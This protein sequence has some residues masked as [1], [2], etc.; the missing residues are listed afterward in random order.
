MKYKGEVK[1]RT[2]RFVYNSISSALYQVTSIAGGFILTRM[3][4][5]TYGS[6][7]NG[8]VI[9]II[10]FVSYF[11][12]VE[13]GLGVALI[14]SLYKPLAL[15]DT[16]EINGIVSLAK[17]SYI[18]ASG[19]YFLLVIGLSL[20]Y[21]LIVK[22]ESTKLITIT[23]LVLVIG[24]FGALEFFIMAKFRVLLIADQKEY[25]ISIVLIISY[26]VNFILSFYMIKMNTYIV[27]VRMIPIVAFSIRALLLHL[28]VKRNYP[29]IKYNESTDKGH[30]HRRWDALIMQLSVS[31][32]I[33][34]PIVIISVFTSLKI[35]SVFSI[36]DLVFAGLIAIISVFT[37]GISASFGNLVANNE[38]DKLKII[39]IEFEFSIYAITAFLYSCALILI[40]S[41]I[42]LYTHGV[43]DVNY[44]NSLYGYLFV[45]WGILYNVRIPYTAL[46]NSRGLYHETRNI[47]ILQVVL[48]IVLAIILVQFYEMTGVLIAMILSALFWVIGLVLVV[49]Q[50]VLSVSPRLT[51]FRVLRMF[52]IV[53]VSN[54]PFH[55]GIK[56]NA[57]T[58]GEWLIWG[59][60]VAAWCLIVTVLINY[61]LDKQVF[62]DTFLRVKLMMPNR[63]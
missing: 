57:E 27:F 46:I 59:F 33:T 52:F 63:R 18:K 32:N 43:T 23:Q 45:T 37:A 29:Y 7:I 11:N 28:Y 25:V 8:L 6:E 14:Y 49:N 3:Y 61:L 2:K 58:F 34:I 53:A 24:V 5:T 19:M 39:Q 36:Y 30:L 40:D 54:I 41:F 62:N 35:A 20:L 26:I 56:I 55:I 51:F 13:A 10:Q 12:Y 60:I 22:S 16:K 21:P 31:V 42:E 9:S 38:L 15:K 48:I 17:K 44:M 47:N 4:L 50:L 1:V